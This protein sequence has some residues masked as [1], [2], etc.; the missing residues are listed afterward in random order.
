MQFRLAPILD[1]MENLYRLPRT[2]QRFSTYL[3]MLQGETKDDMIMPIAGYN[4]MGKDQV[5]EKLLALQNLGAERIVATQLDHINETIK[6]SGRED[7]SVVLNLADDIGGAWTDRYATDYSSKFDL[8]ALIKRNFCTPYFWT[9]ED[10]TSE[11]IHTRTAEYVYRTYFQISHQRPRNLRDHFEQEIFVHD[12]IGHNESLSPHD[13][14][15]IAE[16]YQRHK[17]SE[18]YDLIFNFF[19]GDEASASLGYATHGRSA[20]EGFAFAK[21]MAQ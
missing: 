3:S 10:F 12:Q 9:S 18:A 13:F 19:Y 5:L 11:L 21:F 16:F 7:I 20:N 6:H 4:P 15:D 2:G 17:Q 8:A 1:Q 14:S